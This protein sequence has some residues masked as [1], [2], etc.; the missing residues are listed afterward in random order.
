MT[1]I[2]TNFRIVDPPAP[3]LFIKGTPE[4]QNIKGHYRYQWPVLH[5]GEEKVFDAGVVLSDAM[6][7]ES[8]KYRIEHDPEWQ[9]REDELKRV[10]FALLQRPGLLIEG[11]ADVAVGMELELDVKN[12]KNIENLQETKIRAVGVNK[13]LPDTLREEP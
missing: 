13:K 11:Y 2:E 12:R 5:E 6:I 8:L 7:L 1:D 10:E 4:F 9:N 3:R